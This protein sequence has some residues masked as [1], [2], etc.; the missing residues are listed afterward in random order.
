MTAEKAQLERLAGEPKPCGLR[1]TQTTA[2]P[3]RGDSVQQHSLA[4]AG[5]TV[6]KQTCYPGHRY[7]CDHNPH[8]F[9]S[10]ATRDASTTSDARR[11]H[12]SANNSPGSKDGQDKVELSDLDAS[13]PRLAV[14]QDLMQL[15][16]LGELRAV[17]KLFDSGKESARS[18]DEQGITAL[19]VCRGDI[20]YIQ[21]G[22]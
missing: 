17:Q 4:L 10:M 16:R 13:P 21:G 6:T 3:S 11:P 9:S 15:A 8:T 5:A 2:Q 19:H 22:C 7:I 18:T 12:D 20:E 14:E 1:Q